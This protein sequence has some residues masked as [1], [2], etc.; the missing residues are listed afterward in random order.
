VCVCVCV[1][2][3]ITTPSKSENQVYQKFG[4]KKSKSS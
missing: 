3:V 2:E 4:A 1:F